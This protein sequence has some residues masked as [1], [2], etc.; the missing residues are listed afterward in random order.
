M[1]VIRQNNLHLSINKTQYL[2]DQVEFFGTAYTTKGHKP[3]SDKIK[4]ITE[5]C[6]PT[7]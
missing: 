1:Q 3:T 7:K 2:K 5:M 4:A 6:Q